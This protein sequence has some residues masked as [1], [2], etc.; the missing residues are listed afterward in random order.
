MNS[1]ERKES[2]VQTKLSFFPHNRPQWGG[3]EGLEP[4]AL[5][6]ARRWFQEDGGGS[7]PSPVIRRYLLSSWS[8]S[9]HQCS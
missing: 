4:G 8:N 1:L 3:C 6:R 7:N 5:K 2:G 9:Y